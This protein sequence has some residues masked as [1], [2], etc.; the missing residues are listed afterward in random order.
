MNGTGSVE[1]NCEGRGEES[2]STLKNKSGKLQAMP[3]EKRL[4]GNFY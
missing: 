1:V 2:P 3:V 4:F